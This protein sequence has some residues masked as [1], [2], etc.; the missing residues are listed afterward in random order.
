M[1]TNGA[2]ERKNQVM[3]TPEE[4]AS[5]QEK[6]YESGSLRDDL[7]DTEAKV[8]LEWGQKQVEQMAQKFP[9][10][11]EQKTRF[12][13]QLIK[14]IN[15][16]VGQ[17]EFND[18]AGQQEYM[19]DVVKY[20]APLGYSGNE[21]DLFAVLPDDAK[22]M[23]AN[24]NALLAKLTPPQAQE[25]APETPAGPNAATTSDDVQT[26]SDADKLLPF[27]PNTDKTEVIPDINQI[28]NYKLESTSNPSDLPTEV[29]PNIADIVERIEAEHQQK[30][31]EKPDTDSI[32]HEETTEETGE[33]STHGE[34]E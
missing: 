16:F 6:L 26:Q 27:S 22:D 11:F 20:L 34:K 14:N 9:N 29:L 12:L 18:K 8:L 23:M 10:E 32:N 21:D 33:D 28:N 3:P 4:I 1:Q 24:L 13:R 30:K 7:N 5:E 19:A 25:A 17:R 31:L 15:R 2:Q